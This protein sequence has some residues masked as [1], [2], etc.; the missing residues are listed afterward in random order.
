MNF[1]L[2][3]DL[4]SALQRWFPG[5]YARW[6]HPRL[7]RRYEAARGRFDP[8]AAAVV[9]HYG[10]IVQ[11]GPFAGLRYLAEARNSGF[12]AKILGSYE[13][14]I[15]PAVEAVVANGYRTMVNVGCAEGY[16]AVGLA[17]ASPRSTVYAFDTQADCR[18]LC[19]EL[20]KLNGVGAR[21]VIGAECTHA[22]LNRLGDGRVFLLCDC[23]G[24]ELELLDPAK[25]P[26]L[27]GWDILVEL[28]ECH[29]QGLTATV[30]G[31]F[32]ATHDIELIESVEREPDEFPQ[33]DFLGS[34]Q[35]R[36]IA[37]SDV[38]G[39]WQQ[40]AWMRARVPG[41]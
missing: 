34:R 17:V 4:K 41:R 9:E 5:I 25:V 29:R 6:I 40:W 15:R 38:R 3:Y 33:A 13:A 28:H 36:A 1:K 16:Y 23:E 18:A 14:E 19:G 11:A 35:D 22:E 32:S 2:R 26:A 12:T 8:L 7:L 31:R 30:T 20:A 27:R 24:F 21:V 37:V 39:D 10:L